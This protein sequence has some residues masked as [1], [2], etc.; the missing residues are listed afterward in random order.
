VEV[1]TA[2]LKTSRFKNC[3][4]NQGRP[5]QLWTDHKSLIFAL[6]RVSPPTSGRQQHHLAFIL[7]YTNQLVYV[8]GKANVVADAL[9]CLLRP[10]PVSP[11]SAQ[12]SP[13]GLPWISRIWHSARSSAH[14]CRLSVP[15]QVY[16]SSHRRSAILTSSAIPPPALSAR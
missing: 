3:C 1:D 6:N 2:R 14:R 4:E 15:V 9:S 5:F 12:P 16:A 13:T 11:G 8:T 10:Q 7:E